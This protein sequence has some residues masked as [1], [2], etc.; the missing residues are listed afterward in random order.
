MIKF[1][2]RCTFIAERI[3]RTFFIVDFDYWAFYSHLVRTCGTMAY[4]TN[5][6]VLFGI[7][8]YGECYIFPGLTTERL[9]SIT[10]AEGCFYGIG[11]NNLVSLHKLILVD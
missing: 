1:L 7:E 10:Q 11:G 5:K 6:E 9:E 8:Y 4:K 3:M 2:L